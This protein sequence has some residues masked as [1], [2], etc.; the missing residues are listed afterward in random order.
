MRGF[1]VIQLQL[2]GAPDRPKGFAFDMAGFSDAEK[3]MGLSSVPLSSS[4]SAQQRN[5][6]VTYLLNT[7]ILGEAQ[8]SPE[9]WI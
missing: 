5:S 4:Q 2:H 1:Q 7:C 6:S 9:F 3:N 8:L